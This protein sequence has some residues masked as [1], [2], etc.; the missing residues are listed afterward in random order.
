MKTLLI[1]LGNPILV[2]D[3]V[4]WVV[5]EQVRS[6]LSH[7]AAG[8][9][10]PQTVDVDTASL[11][12]LSL[13]ERLTGYEHVILVDAIFTGTQPVGAVSQF[14]LDDL[15]DLSAGHSASAHDISRTLAPLS[16]L[17][18]AKR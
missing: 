7:P 9:P 8:I 2:D 16:F 10:D 14:L 13:M 12:G 6:A 1:G 5:A 11:G 15:P 18:H 17:F 4:G 3:G